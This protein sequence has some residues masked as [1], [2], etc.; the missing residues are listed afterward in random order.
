M[1]ENLSVLHQSQH[2]IV[3]NKEPDI[4][5]NTDFPEKHP[6][7]LE[8]QLFKCFPHLVDGKFRF[9]HRLD[10]STSGAIC[11]A[12]SKHAAR[13]AS[14][15]FEKRTVEKYYLALVHGHV[16]E[17]LFVIDRMIGNDTRVDFTHR[18][19]TCD[20]SY[21]DNPKT[22]VTVVLVL[23]RGLYNCNCPATKVMMKPITGRR[24][25][26]RVHCHDIGHTIIGDYT[27]SDRQDVMPYR[28]FLHSYRL[29]IPSD[30]EHIDV[31]TD[32]PFTSEIEE[33]KWLPLETVNKLDKHVFD[34]I[35]Y[36]S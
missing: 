22:S 16:N 12:I 9:C 27:Y 4:V 17:D 18:M 6:L 1:F 23:Q 2:Y 25:Q 15:A 32:D 14:K 29:V 20:K 24:H 10:Y 11:V 31:I 3:V 33:N 35:K 7:T 8:N 36:I 5:I 21:C 26:L 13:E 28:M 30:L 19:C 34:K